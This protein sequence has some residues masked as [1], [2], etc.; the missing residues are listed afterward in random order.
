MAWGCSGQVAAAAAG[1]ALPGAEAPIPARRPLATGRLL[2]GVG[3]VCGGPGKGLGG[4]WRTGPGR[5]DRDRAGPRRSRQARGRRWLGPGWGWGVPQPWP[6]RG[7]AIGGRGEGPTADRLVYQAAQGPRGG[8]PGPGGS[9]A[10]ICY[11]HPLAAD[12]IAG[13]A[14]AVV[15]E[16]GILGGWSRGLRRGRS[17]SRTWAWGLAWTR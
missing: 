14:A 11:A 1:A 6:G 2:L 5:R 4:G 10:R 9:I 13:R 7:D 17:P 3:R 8:C 15:A 12:S 16:H